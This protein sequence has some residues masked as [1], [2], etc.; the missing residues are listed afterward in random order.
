MHVYLAT[1]TQVRDDAPKI[2]YHSLEDF[3]KLFSKK[4]TQ[5]LETH[6]MHF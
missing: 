2:N 5:R 4:F 1:A 3:P 6:L